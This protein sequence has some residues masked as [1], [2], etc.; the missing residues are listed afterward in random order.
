MLRINNMCSL[1]FFAFGTSNGVAIES[2][3]SRDG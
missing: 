2:S 3:F 1:P